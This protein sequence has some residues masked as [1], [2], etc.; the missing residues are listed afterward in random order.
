[1]APS[2]YSPHSNPA[3]ALRRRNQVLDAMATC[4]YI[5]PSRA[6][7]AKE[8][9]LNVR[10]RRN[11]LKNSNYAVEYIKQQLLDLF[12]YDRIFK[13]GLRVYAT[14]D[15]DMQKTAQQAMENYLSKVEAQ[16]GFQ[17][18]S[19]A[20]YL[21]QRSTGNAEGASDYERADYLQ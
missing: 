18:I 21:R 14:I 7:A 11:D 4:G 13:G 3:Q 8:T 20:A 12:G 19:R 17:H 1:K 9:A 16:H 6:A 15:A 10:P 5:T 2:F